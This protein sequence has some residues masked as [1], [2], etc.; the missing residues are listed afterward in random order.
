VPL[1]N[2]PQ[3]CIVFTGATIDKPVVRDGQVTVRPVMHVV[4][5]YGHRVLD[6]V[7]GARCPHG[8]GG[9]IRGGHS[10]QE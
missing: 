10:T 2:P 6:G 1:V 7:T 5:A 3:T 9:R 4:V 8:A